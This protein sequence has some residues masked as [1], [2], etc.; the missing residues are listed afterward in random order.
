MKHSP[1]SEILSS[2]Q[3]CLLIGSL[4]LQSAPAAVEFI[5]SKRWIV[6]SWPQTGIAS[7][8]EGMLDGVSPDW[9][10]G[11]D[12]GISAF[13]EALAHAREPLPLIKG[14][15][16]GPV[17]TAL[18]SKDLYGG[19]EERLDRAVKRV[20]DAARKQYEALS[21]CARSVLIVLDEPGL[22]SWKSLSTT[23]RARCLEAFSYITVVLQELGIHV[24]LHACC[25][26]DKVLLEIPVELL[27]FDLY[28]ADMEA[29]FDDECTR[30][31]RDG[32]CRGVI[33][34][35]GIVPGNAGDVRADELISRGLEL[36]KS[37]SERLAVVIDGHEFPRLLWSA[38]CGHAAA[39]KEWMHCLYSTPLSLTE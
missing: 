1:L 31:W 13:K 4:P 35:P 34:V 7:G 26:F 19:I 27:S 6:P 29:L 3:Q 33:L 9:E 30:L 36:L 24:G 15:V 18:Y 14:H 16:A 20:I 23:D 17:T 39:S 11:G 5:L 25:T 22:E 37:F 2:D 12:P 21:R 38:N 10:A 8:S 28:S 32:A